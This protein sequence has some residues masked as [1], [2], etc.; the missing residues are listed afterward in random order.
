MDLEEK[1]H[2]LSIRVRGCHLV[3]TGSAN[4]SN[5]GV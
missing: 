4:P 5:D 1:I 2:N 3:G